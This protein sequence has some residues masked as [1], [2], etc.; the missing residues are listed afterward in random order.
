[1]NSKLLFGIL[2]LVTGIVIS[3]VAAYFSIVGL[4]ALFAS[5]GLAIAVM[6]G[7]LEFGKLV[8]WAWLKLNWKTA[9][10]LHNFFLVLPI[11]A[12]M[13]ITSL[14]IYGFLS[15]GHLEQKAPLAGMELNERQLETRIQQKVQENERLN[16]RL[17]QI[18]RNIAVFLENDRATQ[19]LSASNRMKAERDDIQ[20][21]I[22]ENNEAINGL[23]EEL[24]PMKVESSEVEAKLGP[25][26]YVAALFGWEDAEVAVR[27]VI[28]LIMVAFDPLA[29]M[30]LISAMITLS[31][32]ARERRE[33]K[34]IEEITKETEEVITAADVALGECAATPTIEELRAMVSEMLAEQEPEEEEAPEVEII[35]PEVEVEEVEPVEAVFEEVSEITEDDTYDAMGYGAQAPEPAPIDEFPEEELPEEKPV[36]LNRDNVLAFLEENPD[37]VGE[38]G[39]VFRENF[40]EEMSDR[41]K[42]L[43][44]LE[45]NPAI[46][47]D[48]AAII[49][50]GLTGKG[51]EKDDKPSSNG[52]TSWL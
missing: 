6:G 4:M 48:M 11:A 1:M 41:E 52:G 3:G 13:V 45:K 44:L 30:L 47:N 26:K 43:D 19:G 36:P 17:D 21:K 39:S 29:V 32:W 37:F 16:S 9:P 28:I 12:L 46:I 5:A 22:D 34:E 35:E 49:A 42:L 14:G 40:E 7:A 18:D 15:A 20:R 10:K 33:D 31:G 8:A 50:T 24:V 25:V 2:T 51:E 27:F 38:I 23:N